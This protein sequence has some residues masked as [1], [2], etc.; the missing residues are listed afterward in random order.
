VHS[1][2]GAERREAR[3]ALLKEIGDVGQW[4][5]GGEQNLRGFLEELTRENSISADQLRLKL[6]QA[7]ST[8]ESDRLPSELYELRSIGGRGIERTS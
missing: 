2:A 3:L 5:K 8:K 1:S 6:S 4:Q 7:K